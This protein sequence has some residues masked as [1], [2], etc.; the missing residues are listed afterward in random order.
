MECGESTDKD[1]S[2]LWA[3]DRGAA[4]Q[5]CHDKT[6]FA[7]LI[8]LDDER[9]RGSSRWKRGGYLGCADR[10]SI[11]ER[12][13]PRQGDLQDDHH[14][15][16]QEINSPAN[17]SGSSTYRGCQREKMAQKQF[18]INREEHHFDAFE[19]LCFDICGPMEQVLLVGSKFLLLI[20]AEDSG[21]M[22]V[23]AYERSRRLKTAL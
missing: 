3:A 1:V 18:P 21:Y 5:I 23:F 17:S 7:S 4:R 8:K 2:P 15:H 6:K 16:D 12:V 13:K 20:V 10:S 14:Q 11:Q 19:L 22:K 9:P